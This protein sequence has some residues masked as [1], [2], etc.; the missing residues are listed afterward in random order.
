MRHE[1]CIST[2]INHKAQRTKWRYQT[3]KLSWVSEKFHDTE[4]GNDFLVDT[5]YA[6]TNEQTDSLDSIE[7]QLLCIK[8]HSQQDGRGTSEW[9]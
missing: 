2:K 6:G 9:R 1:L 7:T 5:K 4:F 8:G 3:I